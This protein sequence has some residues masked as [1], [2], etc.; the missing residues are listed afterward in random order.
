LPINNYHL[1]LKQAPKEN[2]ITYYQ[3]IHNKKSIIESQKNVNREEKIHQM[4]SILKNQNVNDIEIIDLTKI[5]ENKAATQNIY[6]KQNA[7][8]YTNS[9]H[10]INRTLMQS[11]GDQKE[12]QNSNYIY[13]FNNDN[14]GGY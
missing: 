2:P 8:Q 12:A 14:F 6:S 11:V 9:D 3:E 7:M 4:N 5:K 1:G 10:K 13:Y